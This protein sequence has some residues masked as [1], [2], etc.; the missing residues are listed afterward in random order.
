MKNKINITYINVDYLSTHNAIPFTLSKHITKEKEVISW[1]TAPKFFPEEM[2]AA[3]IR[4]KYLMD[5]AKTVGLDDMAM[6]DQPKGEKLVEECHELTY[7]ELSEFFESDT[8][9]NQGTIWNVDKNYTSIFMT[10]ETHDKI[11]EKYNRSVSLVYPVADCA[12]VRYYDKEKEVIGLTHSDGYYTGQNVVQHMTDY[13]KEHFNSNIDDI[14]VFVGAFANDKWTYDKIPDWAVNKDENGEFVSYRGE[15]EKYI[16]KKAD[17]E[18]EIHYGDYL[19]KQIVESGINK[20]KISF[21]PNNT[22]FN[23]EYFSNART[24]KTQ[25]KEG[26]NLVGIT[27]D[28]EIV[29]KEKDTEIKLR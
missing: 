23:K 28:N 17:N 26:R 2:K 10:K 3:P 11:K 14:E 8:Y 24:F 1:N 15:W 18:Y 21:D 22:L 25:E 9:K 5:N 20:D 6:P 12:V 16:E 13:M 27:F 7:D 19:Y 4:I 29:N